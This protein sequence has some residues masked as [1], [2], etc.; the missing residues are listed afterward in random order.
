[1]GSDA[2]D[3]VPAATDLAPTQPRRPGRAR[4][5]SRSRER[6][7]SV[8][9]TG[10][11]HHLGAAPSEQPVHDADGVRATATAGVQ[12]AART[13]HHLRTQRSYLARR[14]EQASRA[15]DFEDA[16]TCRDAIAAIDTEL[17]RRGEAP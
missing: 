10:R 9:E 2:P 1:M 15:L 8:T 13:T 6:T 5:L 4:E 7:Y 16:A 11:H 12:M 14:M 17:V 3:D